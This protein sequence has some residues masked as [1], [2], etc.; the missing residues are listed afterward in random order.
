MSGARKENGTTCASFFKS[1]PFALFS[2]RDEPLDSITNVFAGHRS[3]DCGI[4]ESNEKDVFRAGCSDGTWGHYFPKNWTHSVIK[5]YRVW[6]KE[7]EAKG[8]KC[9]AVPGSPAQAVDKRC[10]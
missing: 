5:S 8:Y 7:D 2:S 6:Y 9:L 1:V 10:R 4:E 3:Y